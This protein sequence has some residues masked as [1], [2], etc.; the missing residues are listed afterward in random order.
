MV[1]MALGVP[2]YAALFLLLN[3]LVLMI[4]KS[5]PTCF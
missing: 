2:A 5:L 1:P 4:R 3:C